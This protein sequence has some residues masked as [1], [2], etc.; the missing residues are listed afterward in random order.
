[1]DAHSGARFTALVAMITAVAAC[2]G[3]FLDDPTPWE[4]QPPTWDDPSPPPP[5]APPP[6]PVSEREGCFGEI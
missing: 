2:S 6:S 5:P 3:Y 4:E 1:M